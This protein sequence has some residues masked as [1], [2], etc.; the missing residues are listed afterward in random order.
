MTQHLPPDRY[1]FAIVAAMFLM[2]AVL[3]VSELFKWWKRQNDSIKKP[4]RIFRFLSPKPPV[5]RN[6]PEKVRQ[7]DKLERERKSNRAA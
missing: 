2:G 3:A 6:V 1:L 7:S 4:S 5:N